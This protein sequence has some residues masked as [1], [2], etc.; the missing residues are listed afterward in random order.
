VAGNRLAEN[1]VT[2]TL[3]V[4]VGERWP[5]EPISRWAL[6]DA[7]GELQR[8]GES[9]PSHWPAADQCEAVISAPQ[10]ACLRAPCPERISRRDLMT[11]VASTLEDRLLDDIDQC[12][13]T[14]CGRRRGATD[15][16][17]IARARLRNVLAQF[18]AL[19]RPLSA[20]YSELQTECGTEQGW[21]LAMAD[22]GAI[23]HRPEQPPLTLD[24]AGDLPP[25]ALP[26]LL[27]S[28]R[29]QGSEPALGVSPRPGQSLDLG[30]WGSL[31][32]L[33][34][35]TLGPEYHWYDVAKGAADLLHDEFA[36]SQPGG[37]SW[38]AIRPILGAAAALICIQVVVGL[39]QVGW[40]HHV[41]SGTEARMAQLFRASFPKLPMVAPLAQTRQQLDQL[42]TVHGQLRSD[43]A[44]VL[45]AAV[46]DVLGADALDAIGEL[47]YENRSLS[48]L[49]QPQAAARIGD[50]Q[51]QLAVR[52]YATALR[53]AA[54]GRS[55]LT[56]R[57]ETAR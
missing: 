47:S 43:D 3:R 41:I 23:L 56:V 44:L 32:D 40:Q 15:V 6:F 26:P 20:A 9:G 2:T 25:A 8:T 36:S 45:L 33:Q 21:M 11:V 5:L 27:A 57:Q 42:R 22:D 35:V 19:G 7:A 28:A 30:Q 38:R 54:D 37:A 34:A 48:L 46:A 13:L 53:P 55:W 29:A 52:G 39:L 50:L 31:L 10:V 51:R 49:L 4:F 16:L 17:V 1:I 14:V 24:V 18:A 12:H